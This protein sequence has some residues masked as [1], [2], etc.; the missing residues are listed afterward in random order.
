MLYAKIKIFRNLNNSLQGREING[1][2]AAS[3]SH[4]ICWRAS[5]PLGHPKQSDLIKMNF[6]FV[7]FGCPSGQLAL[8]HIPRDR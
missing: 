5:S 1:T 4:G 2:F 8:Q 7:C 6:N 3:G